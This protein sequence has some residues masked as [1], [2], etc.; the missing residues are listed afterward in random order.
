MMV[1]EKHQHANT[2]PPFLYT[3][4]DIVHAP[5]MNFK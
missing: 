2:L 4:L 1:V 3:T 5:P